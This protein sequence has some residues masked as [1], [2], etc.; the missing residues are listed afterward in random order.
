MRDPLISPEALKSRLAQGPA[1]IVMFDATSTYPGGPQPRAEGHVPGALQF[2]LE[3]LSDAS[4]G[5][6]HTLPSPAVFNAFARGAGVSADSDVVVY[7]R[8]GVVSAPRA[9]WMFKVMGHDKVCVL[10]GGLP[11]WIAAGGSIAPGPAAPPRAAEGDFRAALRRDL[12]ADRT[13]VAAALQR[14][15]VQVL[16]VRSVERFAGLAPE[17]RPGV[18]AGH[19]PGA[20]NGPWTELVDDGGYGRLASDATI[21]AAFADAG[22]DLDKRVVTSC[23]SGVTACVAALALEMLGRRDWAIYDGSWAEWG[24]RADT[25]VVTGETA[26]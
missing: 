18:R 24:S 20:L 15:D 9:W 7:D 16:D 11:A 10:D 17:P 25:P 4:S 8:I 14:D 6:P 23:G 22:V 26:P 19:M 5:L 21:R 1:G 12:L 2:D 13:D 3:A